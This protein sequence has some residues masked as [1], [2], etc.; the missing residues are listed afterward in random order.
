MVALSPEPD[1]AESIPNITI[2]AGREA[3][4]PC[5]VD[6]LGVFRVAWI[7]VDTQT[8]LTIHNHVVTHNSR[9]SIV[10]NGHRNWDLHIRNIK[11]DDRG[12]YMCQINSSPM[13]HRLG[14]ME[15]VVPPDIIN[16]D[17][18]SDAVVLEGG[19]VMLVCRAS[20][21][22][23]PQISWR[24]EDGEHITLR[25]NGKEKIK[26]FKIEGE[27]L[28]MT[29]LTRKHMGAY[30]C[31]ASNGIPP[32]VSKRIWLQVNFEPL[33]KVPNQLV[34]API[35]TEVTLECYVEASPKSVNYWTRENGEILITS[36]KYQVYE[37]ENVYKV[38]M[39]LTIRYLESKDYGGYSC[40]VK[41]SMGEAEQSIRLHELEL[42]TSRHRTES[43]ESH[44]SFRIEEHFTS[45]DTTTGYKTLDSRKNLYVD[46][47]D[48]TVHA[49]EEIKTPTR[50]LSPE[51]DREIMKPVQKR[52]PNITAGAVPSNAFQYHW[53]LDLI[54]VL[55]ITSQLS[56]AV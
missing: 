9:I 22:P 56:A 1:F 45:N 19:N 10:H 18:S 47:M 29:K 36:D 15:V 43:E 5:V 41:N 7:K 34:G 53:L 46:G 30:L 52:P 26:V 6:N 40:I 51:P 12:F 32:S 8:V 17:T 27:V 21:Y 16:H 50:K 2:P 54:L 48:N 4:M 33:L 31:I 49:G 44:V 14:Y 24:R 39:K 28:N 13:K 11:E 35:N 38:H 23:P 55:F 37:L 25:S 42:P 20:G 3:T